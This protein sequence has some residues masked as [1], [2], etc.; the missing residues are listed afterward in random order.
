LFGSYLEEVNTNYVRRHWEA[1]RR[2]EA[3]EAI[4]AARQA[5]LAAY[6]LQVREP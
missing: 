1:E 2:R 3:L 4:E 5:Q 6:K